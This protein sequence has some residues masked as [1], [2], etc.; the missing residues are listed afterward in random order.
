MDRKPERHQLPPQRGGQSGPATSRPGAEDME[1]VRP[2]ASPAGPPL[3]ALSLYGAAPVEPAGEVDPQPALGSSQEGPG[4]AAAVRPHSVSITTPSVRWG[5]AYHYA[6]HQPLNLPS[7]Y[8]STRCSFIQPSARGVIGLQAAP[9]VPPPTSNISSVDTAGRLW[10]PYVQSARAEAAVPTSTGFY[11]DPRRY[12]RILRRREKR[13][14]RWMRVRGI[15]APSPGR[16][17]DVSTITSMMM[18]QG[19][20]PQPRRTRRRHESRRAHALR[21]RRDESGRFLSG[22]STHADSVSSREN[23]ASTAQPEY[24]TLESEEKNDGESME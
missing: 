3:E 8:P 11:V 20:L 19:T 18:T 5:V 21:R 10:L 13:L 1:R 23:R 24:K 2:P 4:A 17:Q 16:L 9:T 22:A 14:L 15:P 7:G 6:A 12:Y